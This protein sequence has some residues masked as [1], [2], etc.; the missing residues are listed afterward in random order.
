LGKRSTLIFNINQSSTQNVGPLSNPGNGFAQ[1]NE[2]K[3]LGFSV[4]ASHRL[5]PRDTLTASLSQTTTKSEVNADKTTLWSGIFVWSKLISSR[6]TL[7]LSA[8]RNVF[9]SATGSAEP[10]N[11]SALL[12]SLSMQF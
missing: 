8:R 12:A 10:Y 1:G 6:A 7:S 2:I 3:W 4:N 9:T 11:E 5:T